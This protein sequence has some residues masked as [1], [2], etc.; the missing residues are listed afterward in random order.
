[1]IDWIKGVFDAV[2]K[3]YLRMIIFGI[4]HSTS[5]PN[6]LLEMYTFRFSYKDGA[7][8]EIYRND[9]RISSTSTAS[10]TKKATISLLRSLCNLIKTFRPLPDDVQ[11]TMKLYYYD[12]V[13]PEDYEPPGFK[14]AETDVI[15]L[16]GI[17]RRC[18]FPG[19]SW[20]IRK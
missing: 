7:G 18:H 14:P 6:T 15:C 10:E 13:T 2:D 11:V 5:D 16:E 4:Y 8:L 1:M 19:K 17:D 20:G 9:C 3:K 12:D